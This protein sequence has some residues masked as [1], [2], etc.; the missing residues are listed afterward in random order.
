MKGAG[1]IQNLWSFWGYHKGHILKSLFS[2][3]FGYTNN[4]LITVLQTI[5]F[6]CWKKKH[7]FLSLTSQNSKTA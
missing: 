4:S 2:F 7:A 6:K 5:H 3:Y 1:N